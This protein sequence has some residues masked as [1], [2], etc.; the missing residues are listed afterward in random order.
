M[1]IIYSHNFIN[2]FHLFVDEDQL[3]INVVDLQGHRMFLLI[4]NLS[5]VIFDKGSHNMKIFPKSFQNRRHDTSKQN[6]MF[7]NF[8]PSTSKYELIFDE[9]QHFSNSH[10]TIIL[11]FIQLILNIQHVFVVFVHLVQP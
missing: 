8:I 2:F 4:Q 1:Q 3:F 6:P 9:L 10:F 5:N 11:S 7:F